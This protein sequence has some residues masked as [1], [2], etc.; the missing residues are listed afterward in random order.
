MKRKVTLFL[1]FC[2]LFAVNLFAQTPDLPTG[3]GTSGDPYQIAT[4]NNLYWITQNSSSWDKYF[5]QTADI[6]ASSTFGWDGGAGFLPIGNS[7]TAFTGSYDGQGGMIT[8]LYI[9]R[10]TGSRVGLFGLLDGGVVKNLGVLTNTFVG[11]Y[12][13]GAIAGQAI[14]SASIENC[15]TYSTPGNPITGTS[16]VG[17]IAGSLED[18]STLI[19]SGS[20]ADVSGARYVGGL[21]GRNLATITNCYASGSV[22]GT[23]SDEGGLVGGNTSSP[24]VNNSFWDTQTSTLDNSAG[25]TGKTTTEMKTLATFTNTVTSGLTTPWDF[26]GTP[27][28]DTGIAD[29]WN[30]DATGIHF[31]GYPMPS[32]IDFPITP[33]GDGSLGAPYQIAT[34]NNLYWL[35][36]TPG[37]WSGPSGMYFEQTADIAAYSTA[38]I[39]FGQGFLPIASGSEFDASYNGQEHEI[40]GL[41]IKRSTTYIGLFSYVEGTVMDLQLTD[42]DVTMLNNKFYTGGMVGGLADAT[43]LRCS[44]TGNVQSE[45][46]YVGMLVGVIHYNGHSVPLIDQCWTAGTGYVGGLAG[47]GDSFS[48]QGTI[49][50]SYNRANVTATGGWTAGGLIGWLST[51]N[52]ANPM[53][54][55]NCYSTGT[56]T[57]TDNI[58][59]LVGSNDDQNNTTYTANFWNTT[60]NPDITGVGNIDQDP[61]GVT[62]KTTVQMKTESISGWGWSTSI[63]Q[64]IGENYP[65]L[66]NNPDPTLPVGLSAFTAQYIENTPT[67]YWT[68]QS[69]TDNMGWFVYRNVENDFTTSEKISEFIEGHGT[70]TQQQS[71]IYED[72]IQDPEI[73]DKYY[74]WL[75]SIDYGGMVNHYDKVAVLTIPDNDDPGNEPNAEPVRYG[76]FQNEPN[77]MISNTHIAFNLNDLSQVKLDI[78]NL[79]GQLVKS[80]YSGMTSS[81]SLA[82]DG[83][84]AAG[85]KLSAG[86]YL[87][88]LIVNGKTEDVKKLILMR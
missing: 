13:V 11:S 14:N 81:Q 44:C 75:E 29:W 57:G 16:F 50:N 39:D 76:L 61:S 17:G 20:V 1:V 73:G 43:L 84:D 6:D 19:N 88:K 41:T 63:W 34:L 42:V 85:Q 49:S 68:T 37:V 27:N 46:A 15:L 22:N 58:G 69:E 72:S 59:G 25:G 52:P 23:G 53:H 28:D 40:A 31:Y 18:N 87:Y 33:S 79:K 55:E 21:V 36:Q 4:L 35:T 65:C 66:I 32:W 74:Y 26:I 78:Y 83:S 8:W 51:N 45:D 9:N 60:L 30:M 80:L 77:P 12:Y 54:I 7:G 71:Y 70:T 38:Y 2:V 3:T 86:V 48:F 47:F 62:G 82:W 10:T 67:L 24:V 5:E 64:R 56:V